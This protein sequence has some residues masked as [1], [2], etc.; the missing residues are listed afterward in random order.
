[1]KR[2]L[3]YFKNF[4][5]E[6]VL[7]PGFKLVEAVLELFVPIV[8]AG[9][10]DNG[11]GNPDP[12][13]GKRYILLMGGVLVLLGLLGLAFSV[14]A[15]FFAARAAV[16]FS[17]KLR[18]ALFKHI[19]SFDYATLDKVGTSTLLTRMTSDINQVQS[20]VNMSLRLFLRSPIIV[21]GAMIMAFTI[22]FKA[23][24][25]FAIVIPVLSLVVFGI[26]II[27]KPMYKKVQDKLDRVLKTTRENLTG[28]RVLRAF[29]RQGKETDKF[30]ELTKELMGAQVNVG[31][32]SSYL[33]PMTLVIVNL[34]IALILYVGAGRVDSGI[35]LKGEV[36][37]LINYMSQILVELVK[38]ANLIVNISK[39]LASA[40]R[41]A[42]ALEVTPD[43]WQIAGSVP[44]NESKRIS[45]TNEQDT[46]IV[47][48]AR[49]LSFSYGGGGDEALTDINM[50]IKKGETIGIIGG[51]G[52]GKSTLV[53]VLSNFYAATGGEVLLK[54]KDIRE[55][56][57]N[58][59]REIFGIVPQKAVL[60][61]G[62]VESNLRFGKKDATDEEMWQALTDAQIKDIILEKGGLSA[63][64]SQEGKNFSGGQRQR[65]TIAR[66]LVKNSE[67]LILDDSA[68]AL[69]FVTE[70]NLR[71][72]IY[73]SRAGKIT[74]IISQRASSIRHADHIL[75][76][77]DGDMEMY[78]THDELLKKSSVYRD[79][80][81][82][83]YPEEKE[84]AL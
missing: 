36:V 18:S 34:G 39:S 46:E 32:I 5:K 55:Y 17:A 84:V 21:F 14:T 20:G 15:Q 16:G 83:Q 8:M 3:V 44:E 70:K 41:V 72:A 2:L 27:T 73:N 68:S 42:D 58:K 50:V 4:K 79:I 52:S 22:D 59:I 40:E 51:T 31:K 6:A 62:T 54:G 60:F 35:L 26:M 23:A 63:P 19:Q 12:E 37:A 71:T 7:A 82:S 67:I 9:I 38:L 81:Y 65:L 56:D 29:N 10:I 1:M 24:L 66:A 74:I 13:S 33:N 77:N 80:Y 28:V 43:D 11:I 64:V 30:N 57:Q 69:D 25:I 78:G 53:N 47:L 76:L 45:K 48:E 49:H 75:V 61:K